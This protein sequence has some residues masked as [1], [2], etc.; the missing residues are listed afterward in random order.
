[1]VRQ[2]TELRKGVR[3]EISISKLSF[4]IRV[5]M[6]TTFLTSLYQSKIFLLNWMKYITLASIFEME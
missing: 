4:T 1:M 2:L 6:I 5:L 3:D